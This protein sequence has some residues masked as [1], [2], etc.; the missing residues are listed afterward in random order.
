M[1][2]LRSIR[3]SIVDEFRS[4][5]VVFIGDSI[6]SGAGASTTEACWASLFRGWL[7]ASAVQSRNPTS[8]ASGTTEYRTYLAVSPLSP[9]VKCSVR[10][11]PTSGGTLGEYILLHP[12]EDVSFEVVGDWA[13]IV[14]A[15]QSVDASAAFTVYVDGVSQGVTSTY[16]AAG[17]GNQR[18]VMMPFGKH[19]IRIRQTAGTEPLKIESVASRKLLRVRNAGVSGTSTSDWMPSGSLLESSIS[20]TATHV[21]IQLGTNDRGI[22]PKLPNAFYQNLGAICDWISI[23]R[24][25]AKIILMCANRA[26]GAAEVEGNPSVYGYGMLEVRNHIG[27]VASERGLDFI[28]HY[29]LTAKMF[30]DG[31]SYTTDLLHPNDAGHKA[32]YGNIVRAVFGA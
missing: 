19:T 7:A 11:R 9:K 5:D 27:R 10:K 30:V 23:N 21:F 24:P 22:A 13:V 20:S 32:I 6:T 31:D 1:N 14:H 29:A 2:G 16:G 28:D 8:P 3:E 26:E 18:Q 15:R 4:M 17:F 12:G 25:S